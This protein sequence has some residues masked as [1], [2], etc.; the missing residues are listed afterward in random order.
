MLETVAA[1]LILAAVSGITYLAYKHPPAFRKLM[2]LL[3]P[4]LL[5]THVIIATWAM[6]ISRAYVK[7][8]PLIDHS[9]WN[10]A[11]AVINSITP[12]WTLTG[13]IFLSCYAYLGFLAVLPLL[14]NEKKEAEHDERPEE[15]L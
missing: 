8:Y 2:F 15:K 13:V 9:K 1:G 12:S 10:E 4:L 6:G 11:D 3:I 7:L 5:A 14:I